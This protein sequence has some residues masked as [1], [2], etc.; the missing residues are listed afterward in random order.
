MERFKIKD[1]DSND[2]FERKVIY[3]LKRE[4]DM[5]RKELTGINYS[6]VSINRLETHQ[7]N[8]NMYQ[9]NAVSD[10]RDDDQAEALLYYKNKNKELQDRI[11]GLLGVNKELKEKIEILSASSNNKSSIEFYK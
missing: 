3:D 6:S 5:L 1:P 9:Q 2:V 10:R 7:N 8:M 11:D 4:N